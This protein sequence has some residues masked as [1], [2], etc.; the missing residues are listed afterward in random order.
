MAEFLDREFSWDDEI[1]VES[2]FIVLPE[3]DYDFQ[4]ESYERSRFEGSDKMPPCNMALVNLRVFGPQG[5]TTIQ[6]RLFLHSK[7]EWALSAFFKSIGMKKAGEKVRINFDGAI[8]KK[9]RCHVTVNS[10]TNRD[11]EERRNNRIQRFLDP[12]PEAP[13]MT[14]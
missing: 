6:H 1:E 12:V 13:K 14:W 9:G 4:V 10:Y 8:G 7:T 5:S 11:G 3:G 2:E